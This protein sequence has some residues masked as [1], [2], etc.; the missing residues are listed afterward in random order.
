MLVDE[1]IMSI[2]KRSE[3]VENYNPEILRTIVKEKA[4][5]DALNLR[6]VFATNVKHTRKASPLLARLVNHDPQKAIIRA[7]KQAIALLFRFAVA[8]LNNIRRLNKCNCFW[9][10]EVHKLI[11]KEAVGFAINLEDE[12]AHAVK[13]A[14]RNRLVIENHPATGG[15]VAITDL[16]EIDQSRHHRVDA[17]VRLARAGVD[18]GARLG[19]RNPHAV[20]GVK[21]F[22]K[23]LLG[24]GKLLAVNLFDVDKVERFHKTSIADIFIITTK[25]RPLVGDR[26]LLAAMPYET[27]HTEI[28]TFHSSLAIHYIHS[29]IFHTII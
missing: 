5:V 29:N 3:L 8:I 20:V 2:Q 10:S 12:I 4:I 16:N 25:K 11:D 21:L 9:D 23:I 18:A 17:S 7:L 6:I 22:E 13:D 26:F 19:F 24:L 14:N 1:F 27:N 28:L 15:I